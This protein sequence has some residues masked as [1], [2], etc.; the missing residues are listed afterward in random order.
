EASE[1]ADQQRLRFAATS[2]SKGVR[3]VEIRVPCPDSVP[4]PTQRRL[5]G[6]RSRSAHGPRPPRQRSGSSSRSQR[7]SDAAGASAA[8]RRSPP[9]A[10]APSCRAPS[11]RPRTARPPT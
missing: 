10:A 5:S 11:P 2:V 8:P 3:A 6:A 9:L 1:Q 7:P 4:R